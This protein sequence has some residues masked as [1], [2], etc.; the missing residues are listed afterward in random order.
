MLSKDV[1]A[2]VNALANLRE[3]YGDN[4]VDSFVDQFEFVLEEHVTNEDEGSVF[5]CLCVDDH[6]TVY[7]ISNLRDGYTGWYCNDDIDKFA[8][9]CKEEILRELKGFS[10]STGEKLGDLLEDICGDEDVIFWLPEDCMDYSFDYTDGVAH[11]V[12]T[13]LGYW[14]GQQLVSAYQDYYYDEIN[15]G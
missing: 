4:I 10:D 14:I 6:N 1:L 11:R 3:R 12:N 9:G 7:G 13:S 2:R 8:S 15:N 5:R